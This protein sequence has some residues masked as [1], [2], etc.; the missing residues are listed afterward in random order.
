M[1]GMIDHSS[2]VTNKLKLI[3]FD[4][5]YRFALHYQFYFNFQ[6]TSDRQ[7]KNSNNYLQEEEKFGLRITL[8]LIKITFVSLN[9][10]ASRWHIS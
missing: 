8:V 7:V 9:V 6:M 1:L 4:L 2:S 5:A 3:W 10:Q